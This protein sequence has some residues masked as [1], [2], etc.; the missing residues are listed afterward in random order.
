M[1]INFKK[2]NIEWNEHDPYYAVNFILGL[3]SLIL[4]TIWNWIAPMW[5]IRCSPGFGLL[6]G[7]WII[8]SIAWLSYTGYMWFYYGK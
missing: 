4:S 3:V 5:C 2:G 1:R 7:I 8:G 6:Q